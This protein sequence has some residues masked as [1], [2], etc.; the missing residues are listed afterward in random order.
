MAAQVETR[1][2]FPQWEKWW[3]S[4]TFGTQNLHG[5]SIL[6]FFNYIVKIFV[7]TPKDI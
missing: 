6:N 5:Y 7:H 4:V 1:S 2:E 3:F